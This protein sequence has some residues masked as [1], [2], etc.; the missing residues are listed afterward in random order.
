M[1]PSGVCLCVGSVY[2]GDWLLWFKGLG[3]TARAG[4]GVRDPLSRVRA[5]SGG[6]REQRVGSTGIGNLDSVLRGK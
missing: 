5:G 6:F 1:S 2:R 4:N 3:C